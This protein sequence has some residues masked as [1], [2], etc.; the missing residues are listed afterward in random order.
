M[1]QFCIYCGEREATTRDHAPP[2]CFFPKPRPSNLITVPSCGVCNKTYGKDD[3]RVRNLITA[4]DTTEDHPA[5]RKKIAGKRNRSFAREKGQS[6]L[7]HIIESIR[8]VDL[9]SS[10]GTNLGKAPAFNLDQKVMDRFIERI[11]RALLYIENG[12]EYT[13]LEVE[14]KLAPD[15]QTVERMPLEL[16]AFFLNGQLKKIGDGV[17]GYLGLYTPGRANSLWILSFYG[18]IEFMSIVREKR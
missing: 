14:W 18:G 2:E 13:E 5:I 16:R 7:Q 9:Y 11:T 17:F 4:I 10:D 6:N 15:K 12:I 3:E 1:V 8:T